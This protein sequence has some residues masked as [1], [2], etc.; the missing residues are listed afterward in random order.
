MPRIAEVA[1]VETP[2]CRDGT[3]SVSMLIP[4]G[5]VDLKH[6]ARP[7]RQSWSWLALNVAILAGL[8]LSAPLTAGTITYY[9]TDIHGAAVT[10]NFSI[11]STTDTLLSYDIVTPW[12]EFL[13]PHAWRSDL[14]ANYLEL[15]Q[16]IPSD[17]TDPSG[18]A[19]TVA[20]NV[21]IPFLAAAEY[22]P[23]SSGFVDED[24]GGDR[25]YDWR[26]FTG[27]I[28]LGPEPSTF[29]V[30]LLGAMGL[31]GERRRRRRLAPGMGAG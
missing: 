11:D 13:S 6:H 20:M 24:L 31:M 18:S 2:A 17:C 21:Q 4:G 28:T 29:V 30:V 5:N 12:F 7:T 9:L 8:A 22:D 27:G 3:D 25:S 23:I 14:G 26:T 16:C 19:Y 1:K 15:I 10:G